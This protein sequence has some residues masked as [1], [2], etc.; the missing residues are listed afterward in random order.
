MTLAD[1]P[2]DL[3]SFY[4]A[5]GEL[6]RNWFL[7]Q[8]TGG[9]TSV[10]L[11]NGLLVKAS[12]ARLAYADIEPEKTFVCAE[13]EGGPLRPSMEAPFH[14]MIPYTYVFHYHS[15]NFILCSL[16]N[17]T[18]NLLL[19]LINKSVS[20]RLLPYVE[21]GHGLSNAVGESLR[22]EGKV[23]VFLL[24]N[25]GVIV[26]GESLA[27]VNSLIDSIEI[28]I[29]PLLENANVNLCDL[30]ACWSSNLYQIEDVNELNLAPQVLE[31]IT[32][33]LEIIDLDSVLFPDQT[34]YLGSLQSIFGLKGSFAD[35][36]IVRI[37]LESS[38]CIIEQS[39][40]NSVQKEYAWVVCYLLAGI[41]MAKSSKIV[42]ITSA[43]AESLLNNP[44]E[45]YRQQLVSGTY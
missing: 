22:L 4:A 11:P 34:I 29:K 20:T 36:T 26:A 7:S 13:M 12:G 44:S 9:N 42:T 16:L 6:G 38:R 40:L 43:Q 28:A 23:N 25:H 5:S 33:A 8:A 14:Q 45:I 24:E 30:E 32:K 39:N 37:C 10:K 18:P 19:D 41:G 17:L 1:E 2:P 35:A 27:E 3:S 15:L 31:A 21:P